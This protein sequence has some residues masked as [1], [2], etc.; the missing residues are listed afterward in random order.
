MR[1]DQGGEE[2]SIITP[3]PAPITPASTLQGL[4]NHIWSEESF[5]FKKKTGH[6]MRFISVGG[7]KEKLDK[8][9]WRWWIT[10][11]RKWWVSTAVLRSHS[12][13]LQ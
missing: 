5:L 6:A 13:L 9:C 12:C 8:T 7:K 4:L 2:R 3:P 10:P 11:K 1:G